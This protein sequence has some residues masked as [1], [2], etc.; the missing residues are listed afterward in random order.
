MESKYGVQKWRE[1]LAKDTEKRE[2]HLARERVRDKFRREK[3]KEL[4]A[5]SKRKRQENK[6]QQAEKKRKYRAR[7]KEE[8]A[9]LATENSSSMKAYNCRQTLA[10]AV[11]KVRLAL[12]GDSLKKKEV[13]EKVVAIENVGIKVVQPDKPIRTPLN[14]IPCNIVQQVIDFYQ[15][16]D[17]SRQAPGIK[18]TK[19]IKNLQTGKR[20]SIQKRHMVMTVKEALQIFCRENS[21]TKINCS[22]FMDLRPQHVLPCSE[23]PHNICVCTYHANITFLLEAVSKE[24]KEFPKTHR[25]FL[26]KACMTGLCKKC[27][28]DNFDG[29]IPPDSNIGKLISWS[30]WKKVE[31]DI[32]YKNSK[33]K[34]G[35]KK[36]IMK[37]V[38]FEATIKDALQQLLAQTLKFKTHTFVKNVQAEYFEKKNVG[39]NKAV[40]QENFAENAS[41]VYQDEIQS[42]YFSH[43]QVTVFTCCVW[44]INDT[45]SIVVV[46]DDLTHDKYS[47]WT[48]QKVICN[49]LKRKFP[50]LESV[51]I[52]TDG[53]TAQFKSK[54]MMSNLCYFQQD[55]NLQCEWNFFATSHGK[56]VVDGI[57]ATVKR[58][59]WQKVRNREVVVASAEDFYNCANTSLQGVTVLYVPKSQ[60]NEHKEM[61]EARTKLARSIPAIKSQ[62]HFQFLDTENLLVGRTCKSE[63]KKCLVLKDAT[64]NNKAQSCAKKRKI[65]VEE[66][67]ETVIKKPKTSIGGKIKTVIRDST[68][69]KDKQNVSTESSVVNA[70]K[71]SCCSTNTIDDIDLSSDEDE[72]NIPRGPHVKWNYIDVYTS[73]DTD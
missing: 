11:K 23:M 53:C 15:R 73:S 28:V 16:D 8:L 12:P 47:V 49:E 69:S 44:V 18:D 59:V 6:R 42:A 29:L 32:E 48:F 36:E 52:F 27:A 63:R 33:E 51:T 17:I 68:K 31:V 45:I 5:Q 56:G 54:Y 43:G 58:A 61:L 65:C 25:L 21:E 72:L 34:K 46:S 13:L 37:I 9:A 62:L 30:Q 60:I 22:K 41:T 67:K 70:T 38:S 64:I 35:K 71:K 20:K 7:K 19:S 40:I 66:Q 4:L 1:K 14:K 39:T 26:E 3:K 57:G 24:I 10:K 2:E 50:H 55:F